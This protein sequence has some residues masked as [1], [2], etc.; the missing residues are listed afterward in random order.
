M[1][2]IA[3]FDSGTTNSRVYLLRGNK[4]AFSASSNIGTL[5]NIKNGTPALEKGLF[6]LYKNVL[7]KANI[8]DT[9]V[10]RLYM[11][12]MVT[13]INGLME[14]PYMRLPISASEYLCGFEFFNSDFFGRDIT[15][16]PGLVALPSENT[17]PED[18]YMANNVRGEETEL[19]GIM[20]K[21]PEL[22]EKKLTAVIMPGSHTHILFTNNYQIVDICS[23]M[24]SE[25]YSAIYSSTIL[26]AS[27]SHMPDKINE[28]FVSIGYRNLKT[29]GF[30]RALY[31]ARAMH[32]FTHATQIDRDSYIEGTI[33]AGIIN[34]LMAHPQFSKL[35][36]ILIAG[37]KIYHDIFF[38]LIRCADISIP[39][40]GI[41]EPNG[42]ALFGAL[43]LINLK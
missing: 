39:Y 6:A 26:N 12:G 22:F 10:Q 4:L 25:L 15:L 41:S 3:Y 21:Y 16:M 13:S 9:Q 34:A 43:S 18:A 5:D 24:G 36:S 42:F 27:L 23:C 32:L 30:N 14:V 35:N 40:A 11:S 19:F 2:Y 29:Y 20:G 7:A 28:R 38:A 8:S 1:E 17:A 37:A 31:V 33:N